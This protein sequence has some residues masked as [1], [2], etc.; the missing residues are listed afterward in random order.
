MKKS[1]NKKW[2]GLLKA[3]IVIVLRQKKIRRK[4]KVWMAFK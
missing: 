4:V 3:K 1:S 2:M